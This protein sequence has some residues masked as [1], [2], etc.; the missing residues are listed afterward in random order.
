MSFVFNFKGNE[1]VFI[2]IPKNGGTSISES[3]RGYNPY[4]KNNTKRPNERF[5]YH[6]TYLE[7]YRL[8]EKELDRKYFAVS[9]NPWDRAV[10]FYSYIQQNPGCGAPDIHKKI[11]EHSLTFDDFVDIYTNDTR[12]FFRPQIK[13]LIDELDNIVVDVLKLEDINNEVNSY[14]NIYKINDVDII[15]INTSTHKSYRDYFFSEKTK[16][17]IYQHE[18][19][20]IDYCKYKF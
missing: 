20:I 5:I 9:R 8:F 6:H 10:S 1:V 13:Y 18:K 2:H 11:N 17:K 19:G 16:D 15:K 12:D 3:F 14:L 4:I 7:T